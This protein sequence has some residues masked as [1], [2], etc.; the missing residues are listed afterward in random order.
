MLILSLLLY[1]IAKYEIHYKTTFWPKSA[2]VLIISN[3]LE[4]LMAILFKE[5]YLN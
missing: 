1:D 2:D 5:K 4:A 3:K